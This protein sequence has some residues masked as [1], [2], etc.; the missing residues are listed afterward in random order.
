MAWDMLKSPALWIVRSIPLKPECIM[1]GAAWKCCSRAG[2][3]KCN[4]RSYFLIGPRHTPGDSA[5]AAMVL[6]G[7]LEPGRDG[8]GAATFAYMH[9]MPGGPGRAAQATSR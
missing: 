1:P 3:R 6:H 2:R 8:P 4:E 9:A 7:H 5:T